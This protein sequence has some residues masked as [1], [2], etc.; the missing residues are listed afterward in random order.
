MGKLLKWL[1]SDWDKPVLAWDFRDDGRG[2]SG[3][4]INVPG[5]FKFQ[6]IERANNNNNE[7]EDQELIEYDK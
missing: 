1:N 6:S 4:R 2:N 7:D 5:L 3:F